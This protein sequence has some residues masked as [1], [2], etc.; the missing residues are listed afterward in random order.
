M[1]GGQLA[2]AG[3]TPAQ[4]PR[5]PVHAA[6]PAL[7]WLRPKGQ[8]ERGPARDGGSTRMD[9]ASE[10]RLAVRRW[11]CAAPRLYLRAYWLCP[12]APKGL[13]RALRL[14]LFAWG[15][16]LGRR[17]RSGARGLYQGPP[18]H[19]RLRF[20]CVAGE[21]AGVR[22]GQDQQDRGELLPKSVAR[23]PVRGHA[24]SG[25]PARPGFGGVQPGVQV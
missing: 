9:C 12:A 18:F 4:D 8:G 1:C 13:A 20:A 19:N 5:S 21:G 10:R 23:P 7:S 3:P 25:R 22:G 14:P 24:G 2:P 16:T 11:R 15:L 6:S 17:R